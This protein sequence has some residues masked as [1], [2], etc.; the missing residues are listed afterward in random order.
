MGVFVA[1]WA[2]FIYWGPHEESLDCGYCT[3]SQRVSGWLLLGLFLAFYGLAIPAIV[4]DS[5][6][7]RRALAITMLVLVTLGAFGLLV[8]AGFGD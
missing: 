4:L 8:I 7:W 5:S 1:L 3:T 2:T 6:R